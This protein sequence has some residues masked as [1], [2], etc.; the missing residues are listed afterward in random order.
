[1]AAM[2]MAQTNEYFCR[3]MM[4]MADTTRATP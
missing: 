2:T 1:M 3:L 4:M